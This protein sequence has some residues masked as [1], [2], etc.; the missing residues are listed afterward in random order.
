MKIISRSALSLFAFLITAFALN[1]QT[2]QKG[3]AYRYNGK[4]QRIPLGNV[5]I[6]PAA[7]ANGVVSNAN[8]AFTLTL[9]NL[10]MGAH[11][12]NVRIT[13]QG[14]IVFNQQA[15][16][17]WS[18]RKEPL[19][20]I[21]CDAVEFQRQK[22]NLIQIGERRAKERF[23]KKLR[24]LEAVNKSQK[25]ELDV[26]YSKIDSLETEYQNALKQI[27]RYADVF[28]RIDES[29]VD[30]LAQ[31]ALELFSLGRLDEALSL[32]KQ[33]EYM[34]K[35]ADAKRTKEKAGQLRLMADS[36]ERLAR[37]DMATFKKSIKAEI[38][39]YKLYNDWE[40][41][42]ELLKKLADASG[43][44]EDMLDYAEY[45]CNQHKYAEA[46]TYLLKCEK[47]LANAQNDD[48]ILQLALI[49]NN[50]GTMYIL[51]QRYGES[52]ELLKA[53][54]DLYRRFRDSNPYIYVVY[55][56][57]TISQLGLLYATTMRYADSEALYKDAIDT[58]EDLAQIEP[59]AFK[60]YVA[61][62]KKYLGDLYMKHHLYSQ[63]ETVYTDALEIY[64]QLAEE[65]AETFELYVALAQNDLA[66]CYRK[67]QKPEQSE[68][69]YK[70]ALAICEGWTEKNEAAYLPHLANIEMNLGNLY[71]KT[72]RYKEAE[73]MLKASLQIRNRLAKEHPSAF[74]AD[75]AKTLTNLGLLYTKTERYAEA[76]TTFN[77]TL[78]ISKELAKDNRKAM[79]PLLADI[80]QDLASLYSKMHRWAESE[81]LYKD[82]IEI[83]KRLSKIDSYAYEGGLAEAY[84]QL[85]NLYYDAQRFA[86]SEAMFKAGIGIYEKAE[87]G[88]PEDFRKKLAN[89]K[90]QLATVYYNSGKYLESGELYKEA[91]NIFE[92]LNHE[93]PGE[94]SF[95]IFSANLGLSMV[96]PRL[97]DYKAAYKLYAKLLPQLESLYAENPALW[98]ETYAQR[99][100]GQSFIS[101]LTGRFK[102]GEKYA[103]EAL[104][105]NP[106]LD[107]TYTNLAASLLLQ[108]RM[109]EAEKIYRKYKKQYKDSFLEDFAE[110]ERLKLI[111]ANRR[112]NV[113]RIKKM[114]TK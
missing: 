59:K 34:Q 33:G 62:N 84:L 80:E 55:S 38:S 41:A 18:V 95:S 67:L 66:S 24:Q 108:G 9:N 63:A 104:A 25:L 107:V 113:E 101:N 14:M 88:N 23:D 110:Y 53:A 92:Q 85:A 42:G 39:C 97:K 3:M 112:A 102:E 70:S 17:E 56:S 51:T 7:S 74:T 94:Y 28:V 10:G 35:F 30:T 49:K 29:E 68:A 109:D 32:F 8:G 22:Q 91:L 6:K 58:F 4:N 13:K 26:Y 83:R 12:G 21:L 73:E 52:E 46:E 31:K 20:L 50:L 36:A 47:M 76:D 45:C 65:D 114:L 96:Y 106:S 57:H 93:Q 44:T 2:L 99:L 89:A 37:Q 90:W 43:E 48:D 75:L 11:I 111:P 105:I 40:K 15:V 16:D 71:Q 98:K 100:M 78:N 54:L 1:G 103:L 86:D 87:V 69:L 19:R 82:V 60:R 27:D 81:A 5:Y 72:Q 61:D 79:E 77:E 64:K